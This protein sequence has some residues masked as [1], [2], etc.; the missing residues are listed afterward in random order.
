MALLRNVDVFVK[1]RSD[2]RSRSA[3]GGV[4]TLAA[5]AVA[6]VL[7]VAQ[8]YLYVAGSRSHSLRL[9]RSARFSMLPHDLA[10]PFQSRA[11]D[12]KGKIPLR[13]HVTFLH[14]AC[15][16][17]EVKLNGQ[18][19]TDRDVDG[20]KGKK[21][22]GRGGG[23][24][25][26]RPN[27]V[28]L[29]RIFG[30]GDGGG[31]GADLAKQHADMGCTLSGQIRVPIVAGHVTV[32]LTRQAWTDALNL[33]MARSQLSE[34]QRAADVHRNDYNMTH[35]I[36]T[37]QFGRKVPAGVASASS[38]SSS[39]APP[40]P[41]LENRMHVIENSMGGIA[42]ENIQVKLVPTVR[43][44]LFGEEEYYQ[45]SVVDHTVQPETMVQQGVAMQPGLAIGYDVTPLAVHQ[46]GGRDSILI[47]LSSLV[48]IVGGAFVTVSLLTG[49]LVHS[50]TAVAKKMD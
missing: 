11:Y 44:G 39:G 41:P 8:L 4:I 49:C 33:F 34:E 47:F 35:F 48:G 5:G 38:S 13:I 46:S 3:A 26:R 25:K 36:H 19:V 29:K 27:P 18:P 23:L 9:A 28:E 50:A 15:G 7:F 2:L 1:P 16:A 42:L 17:L 45:M 43:S 10:D 24:N 22:S 37:M 32:T 20:T 14:I 40:P 12:L 21:G 31:G 6:A 30:G